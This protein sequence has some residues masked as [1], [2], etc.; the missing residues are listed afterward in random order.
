MAH[1]PTLIYTKFQSKR[2]NEAIKTNHAN[3]DE[4]KAN[5]AVPKASD[6]KMQQNPAT[7]RLLK[8]AHTNNSNCP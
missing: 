1:K 7:V 3:G 5:F 8:S 2:I 4:N 6:D